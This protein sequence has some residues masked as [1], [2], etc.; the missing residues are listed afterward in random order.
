MNKF[1]SLNNP[2]EW[3]EEGSLQGKRYNRVKNHSIS[4]NVY[5]DEKETYRIKRF[6]AIIPLLSGKIAKDPLQESR[7]ISPYITLTHTRSSTLIK[8]AN[9]GMDILLSYFW[10]FFGIFG[11][12]WTIFGFHWYSRGNCIWFRK[13]GHFWPFCLLW[14]Q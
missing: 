3:L 2:Q 7:K 14:Q 10:Y 11:S 12:S 1:I 4:S 9:R 6:G 8:F 13:L 5:I